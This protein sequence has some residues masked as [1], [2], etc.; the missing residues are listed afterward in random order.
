MSI[1]LRLT[2]Y[3]AAV[4]AAV[5]IVGGTAVLLLFQRQQWA[6]LDGALMEEADTA[7]E[8]LARMGEAGD[9]I[10]IARKLSDERDLGPA[11]RVMVV[12][13]GA[14]VADFGSPAADLP[15]IA[16]PVEHAIVE[17]RRGIFRYAVAPFV[18]RGRAVYIADG[19]DATPVR[20]SIARLERSLIILTPMLLALCVSGGYLL[21]GRA[22][23]PIATL[24]AGLAEIDPRDLSR[25]L[26][27]G[28]VDD[29][30][31]RLTRAINALLERVERATT[32]ERRFAADAA[33]ELRTP[34]AVLRTGLEVTLARERSE[35][36]YVGALQSAWREAV[37]LCRMA[38]DLLALSRLDHEAAAERA[39]LDLREVVAE[40]VEAVEPLVQAKSLTLESNLDG[41]VRIA[42]NAGH[43]RRVVINL[44]DNALKFTP[45]HGRV[46][47]ELAA[48]DG[49]A[50]L[51]VSD[52]GPG[53]P[54]EDMP[55]IFERFFRGKERGEEG[56]G[57]G[58]SLC[59]E[60]V[61]LHGGK[62][63][64][65][66]LAGGGSEFTVTIPCGP[67]DA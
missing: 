7:S 18:M 48:H 31:A 20:E 28:G 52:S 11:R 47:V 54:A 43:L 61:R 40:V 59:R 30:V 2:L 53:I 56:N 1:R 37:A 32:A 50:R 66:N 8:A 19:V 44:L 60:V 6:R 65:A 29:E 27:I 39:P 46:A 41:P 12:S 14:V 3:W 4:L 17:G 64:A 67:R 62:I 22:L 25:R 26:A 58:L 21:A 55:L 13:G 49:Q 33:H 42:G 51:S 5:M 23:V 57:L 35:A 36:D 63:S 16:Q 10:A 45:A 38:D 15:L 34:L 24:A 9:E